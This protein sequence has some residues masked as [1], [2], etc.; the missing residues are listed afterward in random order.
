MKIQTFSILAGSEACN[1]HCPFC[2]SKMTPSSGLSNKL[3]KVNWRTFAKACQFARDNH[4]STVLITG[5]G[6]PT[7]YPDQITEFMDAMEKYKFPFIELQTNGLLFSEQR[8]KYDSYLSEWYDKGM[9]TIALS[10]AHYDNERNKEIY[11]PDR[12]YPDLLDTIDY[13]HGQGFSVRLSAVLCKGYLEDIDGLEKL[14]E[15][16]RENNVEQLTVRSISKPD[17][18]KREDVEEWTE[19]HMIGDERMKEISGY[20][21]DKGTVL[22]DLIHGATVYDVDGQ[23]VCLTNCLTLEPDNEKIRQL[24]FFPDGHLRYD[25]Q[26]EGAILL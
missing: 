6:E 24:I 17:K 19:N 4:V 13:L 20:L 1:A 25:W 12:E 26:Y 14:I 7:L 10:I 3:D 16:A 9:T 23:N 22:M 18:C 15:F 5:K 11:T 21:D 2:I 8:E